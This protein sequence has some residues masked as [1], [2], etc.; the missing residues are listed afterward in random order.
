MAGSV[1]GG[2]T[3]GSADGSSGD[4]RG[5]AADTGTNSDGTLRSLAPY[6]ASLPALT[7]VL[8]DDDLGPRAMSAGLI[9]DEPYAWPPRSTNGGACGGC[10]E[11]GDRWDVHVVVFRGAGLLVGAWY[12]TVPGRSD[13]RLVTLAAAR[14]HL[15]AEIDG[16]RDVDPIE[17]GILVALR[18]RLEETRARLDAA[19][20]RR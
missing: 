13:Y 17:D 2:C 4:R 20:S 12:P 7:L 5:D 15:D 9:G 14:A 6:H 10:A 1:L 18:S 16:L 19:F 11:P 3:A 8:D